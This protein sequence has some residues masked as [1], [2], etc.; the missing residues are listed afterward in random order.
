MGCFA[1]VCLVG[2]FNLFLLLQKPSQPKDPKT[3]VVLSKASFWCSTNQKHLY[4][5]FH[6]F[7]EEKITHH[8]HYEK[9][10]SIISSHMS[11]RTAAPLARRGEAH[12]RLAPPLPS[13]RLAAAFPARR[14]PFSSRRGGELLPHRAPLLPLPASCRR[15]GGGG[16]DG[17]RSSSFGAALLIPARR[18][19]CSSPAGRRSSSSGAALLVPARRRRCSSP[20][21]RRLSSSSAGL[22]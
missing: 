18:R 7:L 5:C 2:L 21:G 20:V 14:R 6:L 13:G 11:S 8:Y 17:R 3:T 4:P 15:G 12:V 22:P 19:R 1:W 9:N 10:A 16:E